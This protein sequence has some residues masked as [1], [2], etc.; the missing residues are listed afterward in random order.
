MS[1]VKQVDILLAEDNSRDAE[2][3][4]CAL[5]Q[6]N[7]ANNLIRVKDGA[8]ALDLIFGRNGQVRH[9]PKVIL[10]DLKMPKVDGLEVLRQ[11]KSDP[12]TKSIPVVVL[13]SS[14]QTNDFVESY[15][16]GANSYIV[17]PVSFENFSK[18]VADLG[19]Y[20][21]NLNQYSQ[22]S[23]SAASDSESDPAN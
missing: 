14:Q 22:P 21:L 9:Q 4:I 8:E 1:E 2:L 16:L 3:T 20:W 6:H 15:M 7:L 19:H 10:L 11:I 13:T 18:A 5:K 12:N 17:K 23:A